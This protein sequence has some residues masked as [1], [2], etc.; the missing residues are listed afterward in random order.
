M[1]ITASHCR[2]VGLSKYL[3]ID[4][5]LKLILVETFYN[6]CEVYK[7]KEVSSEAHVNILKK[8]SFG[9]K[10]WISFSP[11][12]LILTTDTNKATYTIIALTQPA[13]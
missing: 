3:W 5:K 2:V 11:D 8:C 4:I 9:L 10:P 6:L 13:M 7:I 1:Q 12:N